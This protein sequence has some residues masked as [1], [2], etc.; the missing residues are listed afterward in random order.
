MVGHFIL[1]RE[2]IWVCHGY[3]EMLRAGEWPDG[4]RVQSLKSIVSIEEFGNI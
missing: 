1:T 2:R 3:G 4:F